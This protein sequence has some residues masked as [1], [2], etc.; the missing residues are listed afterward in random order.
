MTAYAM[1]ENKDDSNSWLNAQRLSDALG[2]SLGPLLVT[3]FLSETTTLNVGNDSTDSTVNITAI[4]SEEDTR[5]MYGFL[6][7]GAC[8]FLCGLLMFGMHCIFGGVYIHGQTKHGERQ[9]VTPREL[10]LLKT[11]IILLLIIYFILQSVIFRTYTNF[12]TTFTVNWLGWSKSKGAALT[13]VSKLAMI[14]TIRFLSIE[15]I[16]FSGLT[17]LTVASVGLCFIEM[18]D[19]LPWVFS[20]L[21]GIAI[22][23]PLAVTV[24][25]IDKYIGLRGLISILFSAGGSAGEIIMSPIIGILLERQMYRSYMYLTLGSSVGCLLTMV[26]LQVL[27]RKYKKKEEYLNG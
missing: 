23:F 26:V 27:G 22:C 15:T 6:I 3:P 12:I 10:L 19:S 21:L 14:F 13:S 25:W 17:L 2:G 20:I 16:L 18:H 5:I 1:W 24:G 11:A 4:G 7:G 9:V 8:V